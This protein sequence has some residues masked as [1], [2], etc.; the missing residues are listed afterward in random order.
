MV[1]LDMDELN[2]RNLIQ[3]KKNRD[4][5]IRTEMKNKKHLNITHK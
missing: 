4:I 3:K 1:E 5:K 2:I